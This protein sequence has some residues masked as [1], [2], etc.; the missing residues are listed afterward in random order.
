[1]SSNACVNF[2]R[3]LFQVGLPDFERYDVAHITI[4]VIFFNQVVDVNLVDT[5]Y[6]E[7]IS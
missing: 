6:Y 5:N 1:M 4:D 2:S 3:R 7:N